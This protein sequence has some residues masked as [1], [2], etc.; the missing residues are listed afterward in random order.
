MHFS[1]RAL[2]LF[3]F[4]YTVFFEVR[5]SEND[6]DIFIHSIYVVG[7]SISSRS[8]LDQTRFDWFDIM[9]VMA[10]PM[11]EASDFDKPETDVV[12]KMVRNHSYSEGDFGCS[13]VPELIARAHF[14]GTKVLLSILGD[15]EY[16][17][18]AEDPER[19]RK[20][21]RV[22]SSFVAKY[23]FDGVDVDWE[24]TLDLELHIALLTDLRA[25]LDELG[26]P[27]VLRNY[28]LTTAIHSWRKY[29]CEQA[30]RLCGVIDWVNVMTYD[31][32]GGIWGK[33]PS[34][35]APLDKIKKDLKNW[36]MF[37][38]NKICIGL[39][40]YGFYYR[41]ILPGEMSDVPLGEKNGRY[42]D[43]TE[44]TSLV[45]NGWTES[46]D[47]CAE[48][49]YYYSPDKTEFV[50]I[51]NSH[52][53]QLKLEW[54]LQCD[55]R[56]VFWWEFQSDYFP[57]EAGFDFARHPLIDPIAERIHADRSIWERSSDSNSSNTE[58]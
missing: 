18:V 2:F 50:T 45:S 14:D 35:N 15:E 25:A 1:V 24:H 48:A 44:L 4:C 16:N 5:A 22:I 27:T 36:R 47:F 23:N 7:D 42:F 37:P 19:R 30:S 28:F 46:Y 54:A 56:G 34:H 38:S 41:G 12:Q 43:Y 57:A 6:R 32:G 10:S 58:R 9:Y 3:V 26:K 51:D 52:S 21:A 8:Q 39:A 29:T 55:Y 33:T 13:L 31:M 49:P 53:L 11:W 40:N 20:F 17:L